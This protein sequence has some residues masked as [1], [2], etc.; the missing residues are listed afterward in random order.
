MRKPLNPVHAAAW[1]TMTGFVAFA[2]MLLESGTWW[3]GSAVTDLGMTTLGLCAGTFT[4]AALIQNW[5]L[6]GGA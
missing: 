2:M 5:L 3:P 6:K 1:G 4:A